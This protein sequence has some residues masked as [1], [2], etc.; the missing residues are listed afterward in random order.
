MANN[1][2]LAHPILQSIKK[3]LLSTAIDRKKQ[4]KKINRQYWTD[5]IFDI[6]EAKNPSDFLRIAL[7]DFGFQS[8][9]EVL[10][11]REEATNG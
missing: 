3:K 11:S 8:L 2:Q 5:V 10:G 4:D 7:Y 1:K 6:R 9:E